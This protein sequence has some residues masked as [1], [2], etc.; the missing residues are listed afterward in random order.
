M[1]DWLM[2]MSSYLGWNTLAKIVLALDSSLQGDLSLCETAAW[3]MSGLCYNNSFFL[4][5]NGEIRDLN[6]GCRWRISS[7]QV[8]AKI[9]HYQVSKASCNLYMASKAQHIWHTTFSIGFIV[10]IR[11]F[12]ALSTPKNVLVCSNGS[13]DVLVCSNG[14]IV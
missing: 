11:Q 2:A 1:I 3:L 12:L 4:S 14:S 6:Y 7:R 8:Q 13:I 9:T 5:M 10:A